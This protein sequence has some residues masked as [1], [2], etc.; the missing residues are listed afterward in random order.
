MTSFDSLSW[1]DAVL[2]EL[3]INRRD[4]GARDEVRLQVVWP[5]GGRAALLFRECY[6]FAAEMNF[7][8]IANEQIAVASTIQD[9]PYLVSLRDRW[10]PLGVSLD[11]LR[12]Y[13]LET[14]STGS[15]IRIYA[16]EFAITHLSQI[17]LK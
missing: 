8:V 7:G 3:L 2:Q 13:R 10:I 5:D 16:M 14:S 6:G 12:C 11:M 17:D 15:V 1:H 9:D 4:P